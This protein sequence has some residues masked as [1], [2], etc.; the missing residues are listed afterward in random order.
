[1]LS[2]Y[3]CV[4]LSTIFSLY[5]QFRK[6]VGDI[7]R[8]VPFSVFVVVP[9]MEFLLPVYLWLFPNA[10]P[11]TF[12]SKDSRVTMTTV[13]HS[14]V[15]PSQ[16]YTLLHVGCY[17]FDPGGKKEE[18]AEGEASNGCLPSRH[19]RGDGGDQQEPKE[20]GECPRICLLHQK[21]M[22]LCVSEGKG[23]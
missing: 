9:F 7:F 15:N 16:L 14:F 20:G 19:R 12:Q 5:P 13:H 4:C 18:G 6:T 3:S 21:G 17:N 10:L 22:T 2:F 11:S 1:M 8:V 23:D